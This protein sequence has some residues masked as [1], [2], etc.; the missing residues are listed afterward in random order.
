MREQT[1]RPA[2]LRR[3]RIPKPGRPG[4]TRPLAIP[5]VAD[6]VAMTAAKMVLE[7]IWEADFTP[8]SYGFRVRRSAHDA[9][10]AIRVAANK[11]R[12]WVLDADIRDC[13]GSLDRAAV[14]AQVAS[15][16]ADR[17]MLKLLGWWLRVGVLEGGVT[18]DSGA[19]TPQ[20][21]PRFPRCWRTSRCTGWTWR[22]ASQGSGSG[23]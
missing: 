15:R 1:Y 6:R 13:F 10:E 23:C 14:L 4:Q 3:V 20:G 8:D 5:T 21:S 18:I 19:G 7:P 16:V 2:P 9:C 12:E 17:A 11:G 22:G